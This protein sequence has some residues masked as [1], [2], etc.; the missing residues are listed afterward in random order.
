MSD[1]PQQNSKQE[2]P[3]SADALTA[4]NPVVPPSIVTSAESAT[5]SKTQLG[6]AYSKLFTIFMVAALAISMLASFYLW[7]KL[8]NI[9]EHLARQS[10]DATNLSVEARSLAKSAQDVA[11]EA[12]ARS[13]LNETR[14]SEVALQRSQLDELMQSL[15]RSR[16]EN[17]VVD[18][19][20]AL[21][22]AQ[23][24]AQLTGSVEPLLAALK[25]ADQR[26][27]RAAQPR[28]NGVRKALASDTDRIKAAAVADIPSLLVKLDEI[29]QLLEDLPV[30]N[31]VTEVTKIEKPNA[32]SSVSTKTESTQAAANQDADWK[33]GLQKFMLNN[34][35]IVRAELS[36]LVRV[37][38]IENPDAVLLSPEQTYFLR[39]NLKLKILN[40]RL[41]LLGRQIQSAK[42]DLLSV[43]DDVRK[44]SDPTS[45][46]VQ[47]LKSALTS[48]Q[49]QLG[50]AT[51]PVLDASLAALTLAAAGK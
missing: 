36:K 39:E 16:D 1:F 24:Q 29:S 19:E 2:A 48:V 15:S 46:Q 3:D 45:K 32:N 33:A 17:L 23:Q 42:T 13:S 28:L 8:T 34:W 11:R 21:R 9:Q 37:S 31:T 5:G 22:L 14:L 12:S 49:T 7:R 51:I 20:S 26:L 4:T 44:Y 40:A 43:A 30:L 27:A 18:V 10:A 50:N 6:A 38:R 41:G 35:Q 25:T 47:I